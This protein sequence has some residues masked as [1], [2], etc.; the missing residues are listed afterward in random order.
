M[1]LRVICLVGKNVSCEY[2]ASF[3]AGGDGSWKRHSIPDYSTSH[4]TGS[5][6]STFTTVSPSKSQ[7]GE[8]IREFN[9]GPVARLN[10]TYLP[11]Y[12]GV[13]SSSEKLLSL[14]SLLRT[15]A[16]ALPL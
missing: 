2:T 10:N 3:F 8:V 4:T 11:P 16:M 15:P 1:L 6:C 5:K 12:S 13:L 7:S 9:S 14:S